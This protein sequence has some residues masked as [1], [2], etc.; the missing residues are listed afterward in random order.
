MYDVL[1]S[2]FLGFHGCDASVAEQTFSGKETLRPSR[3]EYDWLGHGVYFWENNPTR[4]IDYAMEIQ[5]L[6]R[7][8]G[9][10][11]TA[12]AA[13]GAIIDPA[14]CLN[15]L[16]REMIELVRDSHQELIETLREAGQ[17]TP[18]NHGGSDLLQRFL[19]CAVL[20][21]LHAARKHAG[22]PD[23]D[24]VRGVFVEGRPIYPGAGFHEKSHIQ[25]CVRNPRCIKGYFRV[26]PDPDAPAI[27]SRSKRR[28]K[29]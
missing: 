8:K 9:P 23:F 20:E 18:R 28:T 19:D 21:H 29:S 27:K 15:L 5:S 12:P 14:R 24:T 2:F 10:R 26:L 3:N 13:V 6:A 17:P 16:D 7:S 4:A 11:I 1:S 25:I 22:F